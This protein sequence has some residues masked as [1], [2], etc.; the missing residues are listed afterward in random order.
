MNKVR[1]SDG[2]ADRVFKTSRRY[3]FG[4]QIAILS[5]IISGLQ[6]SAEVQAA[7]MSATE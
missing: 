5:G 6:Y 7:Y 4:N 1:T 2:T 3:A